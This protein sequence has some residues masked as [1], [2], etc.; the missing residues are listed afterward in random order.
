MLIQITVRVSDREA[1]IVERELSG[2]AAEMEEQVRDVVQRT[3]RV[4]LETAF[5]HVAPNFAAPHCCGQVMKNC[6]WRTMT[7]VSTFGALPVA[8]R[9]Y[10]CERCGHEQYPADAAWCCGRHRLTRPLAKR[11]CQLATNE[12]FPRLPQLLADQH[13]VTVSADTA[14][15]LVHD[16]GGHL[17]AV[18]R[19]EAARG[20]R[21]AAAIVP[22]VTP[23]RV[24]VE[25]DGIHYCTNQTE[26]ERQPPR[27]VWQQMKVGVVAWPAEQDPDHRWHKRVLWG[28]ESPQEFG[29]ALYR[30]ACRCGYEQAAEKVFVTDGADWCW[31]LQQTFFSAATPIV[32]WYHVSEHVW[33]TARVL[34]TDNAA[35]DQAA[36]DQV[37]DDWA[38]AALDELHRGGGTAL[39]A[40]LEPQHKTH[41]GT[42]RQSLG[43]LLN[44]VRLRVERM[45][46][47]AYRDRGWPIGSGMIES[48]CR[49]LVALRLKGPGMHW[50]EKGALAI[51]ALR[52][53]DINQH[54]HSTWN[55]LNLAT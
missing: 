22:D 48:T 31:E 49:Q 8:R 18:R 51:T 27:L 1:G 33:E 26:P 29:A 43:R 3:G 11:I 13:G 52:A 25:V 50:T 10:R 32:D 9:R 35:T 24:L 15:E 5:S 12:H 23:S 4:V 17:E 46:Y 30:L 37:V 14:M 45:D 7:V 16:V 54:W 47:P 44:Y 41:R 38:H 20:R 40:W 36:I 34:A 53:T 55:S 2:T 42:K 21:S 28:R 39:V 6:G 19:A